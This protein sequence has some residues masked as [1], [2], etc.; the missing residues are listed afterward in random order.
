[1]QQTRAA[2]TPRFQFRTILML[3]QG[4]IPASEFNGKDE[5][6]GTLFIENQ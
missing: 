4:R 6:F 3:I 5:E 2:Q 1:L